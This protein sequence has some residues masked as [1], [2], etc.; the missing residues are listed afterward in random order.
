MKLKTE[1]FKGFTAVQA[2]GSL[3][4]CTKVI[5]QQEITLGRKHTIREDLHVV[6]LDLDIILGGPWIFSLGC[7][8]FDLPN[9]KIHFE[10]KGEEITLE[11][12]LDGSTKLVSCKTIERALWHGQ[13]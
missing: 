11:G 4:R 7:F 6:P 13:G 8:R 1:K 10:H 3:V 2:T 12:I 9:L 5:P